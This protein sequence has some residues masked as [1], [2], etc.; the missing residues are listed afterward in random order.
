MHAFNDLI[1]IHTN[2]AHNNTAKNKHAGDVPFTIL[3]VPVLVCVVSEQ[4]TNL[5]QVHYSQLSSTYHVR[6]SVSINTIPESQMV[7][8]YFCPLPK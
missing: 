8:Q 7:S 4:L 2:C 1:I 6:D 5:Q 3:Q